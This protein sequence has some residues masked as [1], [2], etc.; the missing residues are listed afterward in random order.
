LKFLAKAVLWNVLINSFAGI[1][2]CQ[3]FGEKL[4][5]AGK[6]PGTFLTSPY[7]RCQK[8]LEVIQNGWG[9]EAEICREPLLATAFTEDAQMFDESFLKFGAYGLEFCC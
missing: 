8:T 1:Q 4:R 9:V 7:Q 2:H 5:N 6:F 3:V